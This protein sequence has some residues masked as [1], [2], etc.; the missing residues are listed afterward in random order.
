[1]VKKGGM[2]T[3]APGLPLPDIG[4]MRKEDFDGLNLMRTLVASWA[5]KLQAWILLG[6]VWLRMRRHRRL[7][8]VGPASKGA[9][10]HC[11]QSRCAMV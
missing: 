10:S 5:G 2:E 4:E 3:R 9:A 7:M 11:P 1:M 8:R 6:T